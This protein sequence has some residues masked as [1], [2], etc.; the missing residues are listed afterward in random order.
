M[1]G[2]TQMNPAQNPAEA[3]RIIH[4]LLQHWPIFLFI[5]LQTAAAIVVIIF[6]D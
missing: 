6:H 4:V 2:T 5:A 3:G 1:K